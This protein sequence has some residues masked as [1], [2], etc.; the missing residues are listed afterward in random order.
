MPYLATSAKKSVTALAVTVELTVFPPELWEAGT[1]VTFKATVKADGSPIANQ[2]VNFYVYPQKLSG[3]MVGYA[4]TNSEGL[5]TYKWKV[6]WVLGDRTLPCNEHYV[7]AEVP[8]PYYKWSNR[9]TVKVA[10]PTRITLEVPSTVKTGETF[11]I[12]G[13]LEYESSEGTWSPLAGRNVNIYVDGKLIDTVTTKD[14]GTFA[15][16]HSISEPGTHTVVANYLGEGLT[17]GGVALA[18]TAVGLLSPATSPL[19]QMIAGGL[20]LL[21]GM[22]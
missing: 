7:W 11:R 21:A 10:Y 17:T 12:G 16:L 2:R 22:L 14:D 3:V 4:I 9:L 15:T 20:M 5:A 19:P 6:P 18:R 13:K 8:H 1:E